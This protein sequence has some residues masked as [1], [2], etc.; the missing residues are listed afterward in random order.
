MISYK[1]KDWLTFIFHFHKAD[2]VRVLLPMILLM[3]AY[4][5]LIA[6][7]ELEVWKLSKDSY[8]KNLTLLHNLLGFVLSMLLVF[9]TNSAYDRWWEGRKLWG[10][11]V[12]NSRNMAMKL[13]AF[14][15]CG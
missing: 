14:F 10:S 1:P 13:N 7:L 11:L 8:V 12:N 5:G 9:R 2:T 6:Y 3:C 4:S 15:E